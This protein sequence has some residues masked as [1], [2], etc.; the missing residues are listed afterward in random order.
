MVPQKP[1]NVVS[2]QRAPLELLGF[3]LYNHARLIG[4]ATG[5]DGKSSTDDILVDFGTDE[6][7]SGG[8]GEN[9]DVG[10]G[11]R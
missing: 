1:R 9:F 5:G 8:G 10:N 2:L 11:P 6:S 7:F 4:E 3:L